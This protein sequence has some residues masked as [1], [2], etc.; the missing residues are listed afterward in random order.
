M[1]SRKEIIEAQKTEIRSL[2]N[3]F[4]QAR[5]EAAELKGTRKCGCGNPIFFQTYCESC[6]RKL[7]N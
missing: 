2:R 5:A 3:Q 1:M 7:C 6:N 4:A